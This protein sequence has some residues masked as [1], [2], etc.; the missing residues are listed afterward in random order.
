MSSNSLETQDLESNSSGV[1]SKVTTFITSKKGMYLFAAIVLVG[2]IYYYTQNTKKESNEQ[3]QDQEQQYQPPAGYVTVP[4]EMLQGLQQQ[5][6]YGQ[7]QEEQY[8]EPLDLQ[9]QHTQP[10]ANQQQTNQQAPSFRHNQQ[11]EEDDDEAEEIQEQNL[12]KLEMESIQAQ[13]NNMQ[14]QRGN[15]NNA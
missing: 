9:T 12:S 1:I 15:P 11:I 6:G 5:P 4:V 7:A 13:L 14:Q 3:E 2:A 8:E 10:Q